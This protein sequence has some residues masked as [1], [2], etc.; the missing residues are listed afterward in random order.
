MMRLT[1]SLKKNRNKL[2]S[3]N[4]NAKP[5]RTVFLKYRLSE[6]LL[7]WFTSAQ[8]ILVQLWSINKAKES[9]NFN[10]S[11][12]LQPTNKRSTIFEW[13]ITF[14]LKKQL[15]K[16]R[17]SRSWSITQM[18]W[19]TQHRLKNAMC[20]ARNAGKEQATIITRSATSPKKMAI[21]W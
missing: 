9:M 20:L 4:L 2:Q 11:S 10:K 5:K 19:F 1:M 16:A 12:L 17:L 14:T 3:L 18:L 21:S 7:I 15:K 6:I 13:V 8:R